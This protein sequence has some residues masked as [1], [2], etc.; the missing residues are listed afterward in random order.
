MGV[1][2]DWMQYPAVRAANKVAKAEGEIRGVRDALLVVLENR[3][4][5]LPAW[6]RQ[7]IENASR[8]VAM[9]WLVKAGDVAKLT[10]LIPRR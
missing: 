3:F 1:T 2:I 10:D 5:L 8:Q 4:G 9:E 6:A 7:K